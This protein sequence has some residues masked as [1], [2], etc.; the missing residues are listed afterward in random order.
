[1]VLIQVIY[2]VGVRCFNASTVSTMNGSMVHFF[3]KDEVISF[4]TISVLIMILAVPANILVLF[5]HHNLRSTRARPSSVLLVS[6]TFAQLLISIVVIPSQI[7]QVMKPDL[8]ANRK[9]VCIFVGTTFYSLYVTA[10]ETLAC[11]SIDRF[12]AVK[13][14][15]RYSAII[16]RKRVIAVVVF[17]WIHA[18]IFETIIGPF[19]VQVEYNYRVGACGIVFH[20]RIVMLVL[21]LSVYCITPFGIIVVFN[22]KMAAQ[23]WR[24]NRRI[25]HQAPIQSIDERRNAAR[26]GIIKA[27]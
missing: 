4:S 7:L 19:A 8:V 27:F 15:L 18:V 1:M 26:Q 14:M 10:T 24:H 5:G 12:L 9:A 11:M 17:I 23:L 13:S 2:A 22:Y 16:T 25:L 21:I 3:A 6:L 20:D